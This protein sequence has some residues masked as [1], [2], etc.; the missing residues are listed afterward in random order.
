MDIKIG[1]L[2]AFISVPVTIMFFG[3]KSLSHLILW[4]LMLFFLINNML[5]NISDRFKDLPSIG[6]VIKQIIKIDCVLVFMGVRGFHFH[7]NLYFSL[8]L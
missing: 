6:E 8:L 7:S 2:I 4:W 1:V 5:S 3:L